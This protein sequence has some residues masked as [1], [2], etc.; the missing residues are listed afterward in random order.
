MASPSGTALLLRRAALVVLL[1]TVGLPA[2][3]QPTRRRPPAGLQFRFVG[4]VRGNR[5]SA[6]LGEPGNPNLYFAGAASGGIF[7]STDGGNH[8]EP[9]FDSEPV[10]AIGALAMAPSDHQVI[11]AG[12]GEPWVIRNRDTFGDGVYRSTDG[13]RSWEHM[14]LERTGRIARIVVDPRDPNVVFVCA[15]GRGTGPQPERG[16]FRTADGGRSW[17]RVLFVNE[18]TGCSGLAMDPHNPRVLFAG[19]WQFEMHPWGYYS[20][21]PGSGVY[22]SR[23]GGLTWRRLEQGL[24]K[25]PL[26]KIDVAVAPTDSNRV[27]ALIETRDQGSLWRS[28][29]GGHSW[30]VINYSR[31]LTARGGYYIRIAVSPASADEVY[32][33]N[34]SFMVSTDGGENFRAVPWGGD[35]HDIWIDPTNADRFVISDDGGL[36]ITT[37]HGRGF[38]RV[39]LPIGQMYH[40]AVDDQI[41]YFVYGNMQD[42]GSMRGPSTSGLFRTGYGAAEEPPGWQHDL[43]GCESGFTI[44]DPVDPNIVWASCYGNEV[45]R[46]DARNGYARSVS[47]WPLHS[48]DSAPRDTRYRCHWTPPLAI[49]PFDHNTVYYGCQVIFKTSNGGQSW[50]VISPDLSTQDPSKLGPSGGLRRDNLGQFYGEV[51]FAI[52]PSSI[53]RGLIWAGTNDGQIWYTRDAGA[54]WTNVTRNVPGL[55][56]WGT[57]TSIQP[58]NFDPATA[59]VSVDLHLMDDY[60]PYI[61]KTTDFGRSWRLI[62][63]G[64]PPGP[65]SF[66]NRIVEDPNRRGLLFA[67]TENGLY[68]SP[69]DGESWRPLQAGLPHAPVSWIEI[70]KRFH[71]LVVSTY[72]RGFWI[73]DDITPLEQMT[74][75]IERSDAYLFPPRPAYRFLRGG[76]A[77]L[78][79]YL[80]SVPHQPVRLEVLDAAGHL[81]RTLEPPAEPGINRVYW[82]LR[83]EPPRLIRLRTPAPDNPHI[84]EEPR[85]R[86][87][88]WRPITHWGI[89]GGQ[90][91]PLAAPGVYTIR[92][93]VGGSTYTQKLTVLKDPHSNGSEADI[94]ASV[95][96][97]LQIRDA[98]SAVSDMANQV[99]W[100][101][102]QLMDL[103]G[104]LAEQPRRADALE[105]V[106]HMDARLK[107]F[108][109]TLFAPSLAN[110]DEK[111]YPE[112]YRLY[113]SLIWLAA[114]VG[115]GGG[116]VAGSAD[117]PPTDQQFEV[118]HRLQRELAAAREQYRTLLEKEIPEF[119]QK[120]LH[121]GLMPL[122]ATVPPETSGTAESKAAG[123]Q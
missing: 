15:E 49:D 75:E 3:A 102:K 110:S 42:D 64:I 119:N 105:A 52:A 108:E 81:V 113:L 24:P 106:R 14:G 94:R 95:Q 26:G 37:A 116:D 87:R 20:G 62:S 41:P 91:G 72:G 7:K 45:T 104:A 18:N 120:L 111:E 27:Y 114:A 2:M 73:L 122:V 68:Y 6:V 56:P 123:K 57:V 69:D 98:I 85:F 40:V 84:W 47:P 79:Y 96:L 48:L 54:H 39:S 65:L 11:W 4:P 10:Q 44:P 71:D 29:D 63:K 38:R 88:D 99:E 50:T 53:Q 22:V 101:R 13:G 31:L 12:T 78:N 58:S 92:L 67:G 16:V 55:P 36:N 19:M 21:G 107:A 59:Y 80:K 121:W 90:V 28:D 83:Y 112:H 118:F 30:R 32:V 34:S 89:Q 77:I 82:D 97:H 109:S 33:A 46:W 51:V 8:W 74:P 117:Y 61:Y 100:L 86:G 66:V 115:T 1:G 9:V 25:P 5:V 93:S 70:Q 17:Q 60:A 103:S 43:G 35:T 76:R 23:D